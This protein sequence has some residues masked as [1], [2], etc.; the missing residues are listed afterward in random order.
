[1]KHKTGVAMLQITK[2][3]PN[4]IVKNAGWC[5]VYATLI[6]IIPFAAIQL[7]ILELQLV[8]SL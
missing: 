1:M 5:A 7:I 6:T 8:A 3:Q 2:R 4:N